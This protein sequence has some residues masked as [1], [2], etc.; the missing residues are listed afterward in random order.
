MITMTVQDILTEK[1]KGNRVKI[2]RKEWNSRKQSY[3]V[4]AEFAGTWVDCGTD[5]E[6]E[7]GEWLTHEIRLDD[8]REIA[9]ADRSLDL[10]I[11]ILNKP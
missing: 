9:I 11:E 6:I 3:D 4:I 2:T 8:G 10:D 1:L 5:S 7:E